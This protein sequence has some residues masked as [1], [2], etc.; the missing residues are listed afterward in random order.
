MARDTFTVED[1]NPK[2]GFARLRPD[3]GEGLF[4]APLYPEPES[5]APPFQLRKGDRVTGLRRGQA[6]ADVAWVSRAE[7]PYE[8][9]ERMGELLAKLEPWELKVPAT[10]MELA[11]HHWRDSR[12]DPLRQELLSQLPTFFDFE[13]SHPFK[14]GALLERLEAAMQPYLPG[15]AV[16]PL[17]GRNA[18]VVDPGAVEVEVGE[19]DWDAPAKTFTPLLLRVNAQLEAA[20]APVRWVPAENDWLLL[21]PGL[22]ELLVLHGVLGPR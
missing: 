10:A 22:A 2:H 8:L 4:N 3:S 16:K 11:E 14:D 7:P 6:V 9:V 15:F 5:G 18:F 17:Q 1:V 21:P 12:E 19:G 13:L 20:G